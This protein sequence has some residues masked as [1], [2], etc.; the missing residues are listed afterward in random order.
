MIQDNKPV[1]IQGDPKESESNALPKIMAGQHFYGFIF[2]DRRT[3]FRKE[4]FK[5]KLNENRKLMRK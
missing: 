1:I 4:I 2:Y 3:K 5:N